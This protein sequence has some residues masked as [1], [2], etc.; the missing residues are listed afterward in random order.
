MR[1][2][3]RFDARHEGWGTVPMTRRT[4]MD[5]VETVPPTISPETTAT[6]ALRV[7]E[8]VS[9]HYLPVV[10]KRGKPLGV[11]CRCDL[12]DAPPG[13]HVADC[14]SAPAVAID[15]EATP[16]EA[17]SLMLRSGRGCLPVVEDFQVAGLLTRGELLRA[18][19][20]SEAQ[21]RRCELC[22]TTSHVSGTA[23]RSLCRRCRDHG[24]RTNDADDR[25]LGSGD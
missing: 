20:L 21:V 14:M 17:A 25:D 18:R 1:F 8:Q 5:L 11:V 6:E 9:T 2:P 3:T 4:A 13:S 22:G 7:A 12:A 23:E 24:P 19:V 10:G 16:E 15:A